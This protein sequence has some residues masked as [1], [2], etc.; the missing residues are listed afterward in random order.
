VYNRGAGNGPA[1]DTTKVW[2][3]QAEM[4]AALTDGLGNQPGNS[5]YR[6]ALLRTFE[7]TRRSMTDARTGIWVDSVTAEGNPKASGLAHNWKANYHDVRA[8][9]KFVDAFD[10]QKPA[11]RK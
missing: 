8:L 5:A 1:T 6:Q 11:S 10:P 9:V 3:V 2:W 7:F 4:I